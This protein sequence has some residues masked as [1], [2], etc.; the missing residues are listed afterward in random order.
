MNLRTRLAVL[1][2]VSVA[3]A[4]AAMAFAAYFFF[5]RELSRQ[6]DVSL[7]REAN[8]I[9]LQIKQGD[10]YP[11][12]DLSCEWLAAPACAQLVTSEPAGHPLFPVT[13]EARA[14]AAGSRAEFSGDVL[15]DGLALRVKTVPV[16]PGEAL[17]VAVRS[18]QVTQSLDRIRRVLLLAGAGGVVLACAFGYLVA[19]AGLR[20]LAR[21]TAASRHI[22]R[23]RDPAHRIAV[24]GRDELAELTRHFNTMLAALEESLAAQRQLVADASHELRTPLTALRSDIDLLALD[25]RLG[26]D[27]RRVVL[28]RI[29]D[30]FEELTQLVNDLIE[31]AR[32]DEPPSEAEDVALEQVVG[33]RVELARRHWPGITFTTRLAPVLVTGS[34]ERLARAV[35]N[36]LDNAAKFA[37]A[38]STVTVDLADGRLSVRDEGPGIAEADRPRVFDRFYR[39]PTAR[40]VPGSG[41]GLAI[42]AQ[43]V[44]AHQGRIEVGSPPGGGAEFTVWFP[45]AG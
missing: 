19:R 23:T 29:G 3:V 24:R 34:A 43:V 13:P 26:D 36:L 18:D 1:A 12:D 9:Q 39:S 21:I 5:D 45:P 16:R 8:R 22:A 11:P 15:S 20:P 32:G 33:E 37:P 35:A 27:R 10:W 14:V 38:G 31:L 17:Q 40:D 30:Q 41:L 28:R 44:R 25:G 7:T 42:V 4:V 2:A 6:L